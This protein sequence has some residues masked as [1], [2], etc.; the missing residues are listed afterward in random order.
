MITSSGGATNG[1][2]GGS[3][4]RKGGGGGAIAFDIIGKTKMTI[5]INVTNNVFFIFYPP[6][7]T[8][9]P[10]KD[11]PGKPIFTHQSSTLRIL[12]S[13][14][15]EIYHKMGIFNTGLTGGGVKHETKIFDFFPAHTATACLLLP[16]STDR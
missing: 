5:K 1:I 6:I 11:M 8:D 2:G 14:L 16:T 15:I 7:V 12:H 13:T 4:N 10:I 9:A 3:G